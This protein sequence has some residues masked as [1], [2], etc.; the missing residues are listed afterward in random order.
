MSLG[1]LEFFVQLTSEAVFTRRSKGRLTRA[2]EPKPNTRTE[3]LDCTVYALA[4][5]RSMPLSWERVRQ[6]L[7][8]TAAAPINATEAVSGGI[9]VEPA[10]QSQPAGEP[11]PGK[12]AQRPRTRVVHSTYLRR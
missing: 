11:P 10:P 8:A 5:L 6:R 12:L 9:P 1:D 2:W 3:A 4:A 7:G